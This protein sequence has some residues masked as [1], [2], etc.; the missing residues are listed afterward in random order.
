[1]NYSNSQ[2]A[3]VLPPAEL[4]TE[5]GGGLFGR[6]TSAVQHPER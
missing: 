4:A 5:Q 2:G 3:S 1:M 6:L